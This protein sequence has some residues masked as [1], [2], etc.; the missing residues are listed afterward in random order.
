MAADFLM[1]EGDVKQFGFDEKIKVRLTSLKAVRPSKEL[2]IVQGMENNRSIVENR[3]VDILL[4]PDKFCRKDKLH[5]RSSGLDDV[6]CKFAKRK[7]IAVGFSFSSFL[8]VEDISVK[9][10]RLMQ[11]IRFCRKFKVKM[12]IGSFA[13]NSQELRGMEDMAAFFRVAGMTPKEVKDAF[14]AAAEILKEKRTRVREGV[15][16]VED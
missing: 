13:S 15:R 6:I 4:D 8:Y 9:L 11:N 5:H 16:L 2:V 3:H 14:N 12:V 10:G 1:F 7:N